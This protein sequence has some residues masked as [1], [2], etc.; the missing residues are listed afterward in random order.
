MVHKQELD[1]RRDKKNEPEI[2]G[3]L[4]SHLK[5]KQEIQK[6]QSLIPLSDCN[7]L[8][9]NW[10]RC[11]EDSKREIASCNLQNAHQTNHLKLDRDLRKSYILDR[12]KGEVSRGISHTSKRKFN[13]ALY[14]RGTT[15]KDRYIF[16]N[17]RNYNTADTKG[18]K[19]KKR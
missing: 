11:Q 5:Y 18:W 3:Q 9:N 13:K 4:V 16:T 19:K 1:R 2:G 6:Q 12:P 8:V 15:W 10:S 14:A 7:Q 17:H